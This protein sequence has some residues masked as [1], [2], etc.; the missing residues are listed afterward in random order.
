[1]PLGIWTLVGLRKHILHGV[2]IP[3]QRV[4]F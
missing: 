2:Q 1:M 4:N 3:V